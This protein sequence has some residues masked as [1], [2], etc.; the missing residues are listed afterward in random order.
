MALTA[1]AT[2]RVRADVARRLGLDQPLEIIGGFDRPN[3]TFDALWVEGRGSVAR[4]RQAMLAA[5]AGADGGKAIVYC[6]TRRAAEE[7]AAA[8]EAAGHT[9][10][11]YHAGRSDRGAAQ[12]AFSA[13]PGAGGG[14]H[15]RLRHGRQRPRRP[16]R[17]AHGAARTPSS[18]S[19][20]RRAARAATA[21]P[22][23][24]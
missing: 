4:K 20:R 11:V 17:G 8:V 23:A 2:A 22:R 1:T 7:T 10:V 18:S 15:E 19:T 12:E 6:G 3:L 5:L 24:T 14:R 13:R 9:A 16:A 21:S